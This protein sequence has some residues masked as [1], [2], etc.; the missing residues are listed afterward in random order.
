MHQRLAAKDADDLARMSAVR[1][2]FV[3]KILGRFGASF[4]LIERHEIALALVTQQPRA[5]AALRILAGLGVRWPAHAGDA[6]L[7]APL[8]SRV[9]HGEPPRL[10]LWKRVRIQTGCGSL[11]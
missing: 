5:V 6:D 11:I 9:D 3:G 10:L 7:V 4:K 8:L 1:F 2:Q